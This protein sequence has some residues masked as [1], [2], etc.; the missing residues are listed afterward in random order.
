MSKKS[1]DLE[2]F[3]VDIFVALYKIKDYTQTFDNASD[4]SHSSLHWDATIRQ[5]EIIGESLNYLLD[6]EKFTSHAPKYFRKIVNFRNVIIHGYFGI[7]MDEVW[8]VVEVKLTELNRDMLEMIKHIDIS[9]ALMFEIK[10]YIANDDEEL[11]QYL[12]K[13]I[14]NN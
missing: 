9:H 1:R 5:L 10:S 7:D 11:V 4:F 12:N 8:D 6:D 13:L 3:I 2:L 14:D